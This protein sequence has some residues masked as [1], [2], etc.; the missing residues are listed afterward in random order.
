MKV[1][2]FR[3]NLEERENNIRI[4]NSKLCFSSFLFLFFK[5]KFRIIA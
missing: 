5:L 2:F 4:E 3:K 1:S